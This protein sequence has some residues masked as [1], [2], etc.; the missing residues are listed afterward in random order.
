MLD[1]VDSF[2][3]VY[4]SGPGP[5]EFYHLGQGGGMKGLLHTWAGLSGLVI[6][7]LSLS[8]LFGQG[9]DS[10][11]AFAQIVR[12]GGGGQKTETSLSGRAQKTRPSVFVVFWDYQDLALGPALCNLSGSCLGEGP[13]ASA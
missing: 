4:E 1:I 13:T 10:D 8:F 6:E 5:V 3:A 12:W 9:W 2:W 7:D 11:V